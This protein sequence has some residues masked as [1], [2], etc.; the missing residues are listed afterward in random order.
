MW[1]KTDD[2]ILLNLDYVRAI[3]VEEHATD[4]LRLVSYGDEGAYGGRASSV[5]VRAFPVGEDQ[6]YEQAKEE[7]DQALDLI[8]ASLETSGQMVI[9]VPARPVAFRTL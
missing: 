9:A 5:V 4:G 6:T 7:A 1:V 8:T 2:S 3:K